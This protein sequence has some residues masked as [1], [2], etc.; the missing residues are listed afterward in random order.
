MAAA[1]IDP[2][3]KLKEIAQETRLA[4]V[5]NATRLAVACDLMDKL[6]ATSSVLR[7]LARL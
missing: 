5:P 2:Q 7:A 6:T 3:V 1:R 4:P